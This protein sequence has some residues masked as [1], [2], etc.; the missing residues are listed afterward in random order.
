[1]VEQ[2]AGEWLGKYEEPFRANPGMELIEIV[3]SDVMA[4]WFTHGLIIETRR[5]RWLTIV[6]IVLTAVLAI[7]TTELVLLR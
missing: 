4:L 1:M 5:L 6:L 7:L 3:R 2:A